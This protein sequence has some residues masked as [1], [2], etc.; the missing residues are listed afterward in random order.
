[1]KAI[2]LSA[3]LLSFIAAFPISAQSDEGLRNEGGR[4][5]LKIPFEDRENLLRV[6]RNNL[7]NLNKMI[8]AVAEDDFKTVQEVAE[9]MSFNEKK[10]KGLS[11]RGNAAFIAMGVKFHAEDTVAVVKAA[12]KKDRKAT[13]H[14]ISNMMNTCESCHSAFRVMEWPN[15]KVYKRPPPM[16]LMLPEG[17]NHTK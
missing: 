2:I 7:S 3:M 8:Y 12:E 14:A 10:G 5:L 4:I 11:S 16:K 13:L 9:K 17:Y 1:M 15:N 6:M